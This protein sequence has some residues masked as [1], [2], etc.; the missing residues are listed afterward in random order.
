M[1]DVLALLTAA[2]SLAAAFWLAKRM[3]AR[4]LAARE[5]KAQR[6]ALWLRRVTQQKRV[7]ERIVSLN[8]ES[9]GLLESMPRLLESAEGHLDQAEIDFAEGAFAPFWSSVECA[10][11]ALAGFDESVQKL[12][13]NSCEYTDLVARCRVAAPRFPISAEAPARMKVAAATSHRM[14]GIVRRAQRD[15]QFSVIYEQRKTNQ[16]LIAGFRN[17]TQAVEEMASRI[18]ASIDGLATSVE[19]MTSTLDESLRR[20]TEQTERLA[21]SAGAPGVSR[22]EQRVLEMLDGIEQKRYRSAIQGV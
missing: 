1:Q 21:A 2:L 8:D 18:T 19:K 16:I 17:L 7:R 11:L 12:E 10:A 6:E 14:R 13:I 4:T 9:L 20:L 15:F 22:R 5:L 3:R